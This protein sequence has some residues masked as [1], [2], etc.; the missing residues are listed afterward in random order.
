MLVDG[1]ICLVVSVYDLVLVNYGFD[2]GLEDENSVKDYVEIK[3]YILV[4]G[5]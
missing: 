5:E 3:L 2:C 4:W 1:N